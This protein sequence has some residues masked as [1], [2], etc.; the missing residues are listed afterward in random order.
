[1][2]LYEKAFM[3]CRIFPSAQLKEN[4]FFGWLLAKHSTESLATC[5]KLQQESGVSNERMLQFCI[6]N[7]LKEFITKAVADMNDIQLFCRSIKHHSLEEVEKLLKRLSN[8]EKIHSIY[9]VLEKFLPL[10]GNSVEMTK[11]IQMLSKNADIS[12]YFQDFSFYRTEYKQLLSKF[13]YSIDAN[14]LLEDLEHL[15]SKKS[16]SLREMERQTK[17]LHE[18]QEELAFS[19]KNPQILNMSLLETRSLVSRNHPQHLRLFSTS[20]LSNL[21]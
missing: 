13:Y 2:Q 15:N 12:R 9:C 11:F 6:D 10:V 4:V 20:F 1:M 21:E 14:D 8:D 18:F 7:E 3:L 16:H 17:K 5:R 19:S